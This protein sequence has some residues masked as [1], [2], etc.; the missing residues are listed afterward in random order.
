[1]TERLESIGVTE[2]REL[3]RRDPYQ[4]VCEVNLAAG[5]SIWYPRMAAQAMANLLRRKEGST[6][7]QELVLT[8][9]M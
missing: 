9:P 6:I 4:L 8:S 7:A 2:L 3:A 5:R 1:V